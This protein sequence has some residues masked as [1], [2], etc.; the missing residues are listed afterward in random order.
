[1]LE[2]ETPLLCGRV[3]CDPHLHFFGCDSAASVRYLQTSPEFAMKRLLAAG[4]GSIYQIC[5]AF[6]ADEAGRLHNPEF[7]LLEWYRLGFDLDALMH[8]VEALLSHAGDNRWTAGSFERRSYRDVFLHYAAIDPLNATPADF[9][10]RTRLLGLHEAENLCGED[11]SLWLD[12]LFSHIVQPC[13][14]LD[15][16]CFVYHFPACLPSLARRNAA[17]LRVVK[18]VE[19][20]WKGVE[21][22][23]GYHELC[24]AAEQA[25]RFEQ[26]RAERS[27]LGM[28]VPQ[29]DERLLA[30]LHHGL[31]ECA[32]VALGLDRLL[33]LLQD[34]ERIDNVLAFP[35]SRA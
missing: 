13:L 10:A 30:A 20:I 25:Q 17:D 7:T 24:D 22:A 1:M 15:A 29:A 28:P 6:R 14:G 34:A 27:R 16:P 18:R 26:D 4:S 32:G 33:M 35:W 12:F 3:G 11:I 31:P 9:C 21:L 23:N 8:D 2:V 5:K 19:L